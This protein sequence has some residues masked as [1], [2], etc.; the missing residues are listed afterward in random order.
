MESDNVR[1]LAAHQHGRRRERIRRRA[2]VQFEGE[3]RLKKP[4]EGLPNASRPGTTFRLVSHCNGAC[5]YLPRRKSSTLVWM[6]NF[7]SALLMLLAALVYNYPSAGQ[8]YL[9]DTPEIKLG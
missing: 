1:K 8:R 2:R 9:S 6:R 3:K 5:S 4:A 7:S